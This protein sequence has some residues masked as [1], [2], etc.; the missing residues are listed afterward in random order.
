MLL[1][2]L[3]RLRRFAR[4]RSAWLSRMES[5]RLKRRITLIQ[6]RLQLRLVGTFAGMCALGLL[7]QSLVLGAQL[8]SVARELPSGGVRLG[9]ALPGILVQGLALSFAL[10]VP[11]LLVIGI[12]ATFRIAGP[13]YRFEQHLQAVAR[14]EWPEPCPI[15]EAD[16]L[17]DFCKS[18]N[19]ALESARAQG[20]AAGRRDEGTKRRAAG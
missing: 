2:P 15:R 17:Q 1:K 11:A 4:R 5:P 10:L 9:Q 6:P 18:L 20:E 7:A 16:D 3:A 19:A 8:T 14:G 12:R 13:L